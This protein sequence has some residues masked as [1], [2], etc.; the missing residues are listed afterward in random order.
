MPSSPSNSETDRLARARELIRQAKE[1][2]ATT[3]DLS[4]LGLP[5]LPEELRELTWLEELNLLEACADP[6]TDDWVVLQDRG[7]G[8]GLR[9]LPIWVNELNALRTLD[10]SGCE[11]LTELG[12][13][14]GLAGLQNLDLSGCEALTDLSALGGLTCLRTLDLSFCEALTDLSALAK[15]TGL[16]SLNLSGCC[17]LTDVSPLSKLTGLQSL[18][19]S[20]CQA[21]TDLIELQVLIG[22]KRLNLSG[23]SVLTDANALL[24]LA[25][26]ESLNLSGCEFLADVGGLQGLTGLHTLNLSVCEVLT[27][28]S[29]LQGLDGLRCLYLDFCVALTDA[30][31]LRGLTGLQTLH[32]S[33]CKISPDLSF[34][35]GLTGLQE[36]IISG[37]EPLTDLSA[38]GGLTGLRIL[39]LRFCEALTD[40]SALARLTGLQS[41]NL[42]GCGALSDV[43]ALAKLTSLQS[44]DLSQ[45]SSLTNVS[46][47]QKLSDLQILSLID[48]AGLDRFPHFLLDLVSLQ[49]LML[50]GSGIADLPAELLGEEVLTNCLPGIR[51]HFA[52][53]GQGVALDREIKLIVLGNGRVGKTSLCRRLIENQFDPNEGSTHGV[54]FWTWKLKDAEGDEQRI[55][56][57]VWDF[58]GQDIYYGTHAMFLRGRAVFLIAW[59]E[60][61]ESTSEFRDETGGFTHR[62]YPLQY[63][64]DYVNHVS[65]GSPVVVVQTK[66]AKAKQHRARK[67]DLALHHENVTECWLQA[68]ESDPRRNNSRTLLEHIEEAAEQVLGLR[69]A[70]QIGV[71]RWGVKQELRA[72]FDQGTPKTLTKDAFREICGRHQLEGAEAVDQLLIFLH[73]CGVVYHQPGYFD[74]AIVLDQRWACDAIYTVL[75]RKHCVKL[76]RAQHGRFTA[77]DL[78][79]VW[80]DR[81]P[82]ERQLFLRM[83]ESCGICFNLGRD[84]A[85][86][87]TYLAPELTPS[88]EDIAPSVTWPSGE[89]TLWWR[90]NHDFLSP[91][92]MRVAMCE[93]GK[94]HRAAATYWKD[95]L[96]LPLNNLPAQA[97]IEATYWVGG[98]ASRGTITIQARGAQRHEM[99]VRMRE[100]FEGDREEWD[101][102]SARPGVTV[103]VSLDGKTFVRLDAIREGRTL[104]NARVAAEGGAP[105]ELAEYGEFESEIHLPQRYRSGRHSVPELASEPMEASTVNHHSVFIS[106]SHDSDEHKERV[107]HLCDKL[108]EQEVD[109]RIDQYET[110]PAEGWP[111]WMDRQIQGAEAVLLVCTPTYLKRVEMREDPGKGLGVMW[112][113]NVIYN[114]LYPTGAATTK[115]IPLLP[116]NGRVED[117]PLPLR[118]HTHYYFE[119]PEGYDELYRRLTNQPPVLPRP[120]GKKITKPP[121]H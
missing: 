119:T 9:R 95:G 39:E 51:A 43:S 94:Q 46:G 30:G 22:L 106:Y 55:L 13:L 41:L 36:L 6:A 25:G 14:G 101:K 93:V 117:I 40:V 89:E 108:R 33:G 8:R 20:W 105:V 85:G 76:I 121:K 7:P 83:M 96:H 32:L 71:G 103:S 21:A 66:C 11:V 26:L 80:A 97:I 78:S 24:G 107:F 88:K 50:H 74:E 82:Q 64:L 31:A 81:T 91:D 57:N 28:V 62:N 109:A 110:A 54:K 4:M 10:L 102:Q 53:L 69:E 114:L 19:L 112:E 90:Y 5:A 27:D 12:A 68:S 1:T 2:H 86:H 18:D 67:P 3:L 120:L 16:Q 23:S 45:C 17:A 113:A 111:R 59:D 92:T 34:L 44:L 116:S 47:I 56:V 98:N 29:A 118:G 87:S 65:P 37:C 35:G 61:T 49:D 115:F 100:F 48:C 63:W 38:L 72:L 60:E 104:G 58:G 79:D 52:A 70:Q 77:E 75:H 99:L 84:R 42:S 73:H 15:L